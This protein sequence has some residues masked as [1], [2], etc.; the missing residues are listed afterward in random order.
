MG[1]LVVFLRF[2]FS[3]WTRCGCLGPGGEGGQYRSGGEEAPRVSPAVPGEEPRVRQAVRGV[4]QNLTGTSRHYTA[5][6]YSTVQ[7]SAHF[8][9]PTSTQL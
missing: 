6:Q 7:Y 5:V 1:Q 4:H 3:D 8:I 9:C 2:S